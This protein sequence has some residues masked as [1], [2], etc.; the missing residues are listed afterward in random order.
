MNEYNFVI[1]S[2]K[3]L[4]IIEGFLMQGVS[5]TRAANGPPKVFVQPGTL[6]QTDKIRNFDHLSIK[7][8]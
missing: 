4:D 7:T 1:N 5:N 3:R 2:F 8:V 6:V